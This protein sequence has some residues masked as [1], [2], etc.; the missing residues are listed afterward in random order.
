MIQAIQEMKRVREIAA[1]CVKHGLG[2]K[3]NFGKLQEFIG[4]E[5]KV[6]VT[7]EARNRT[8]PE[9]FRCLL[10][11]LGTTFVKF[12]QILSTRVDLLPREY[13]DELAK[14]QDDVTPVPYEQIR[15]QIEASFGRPVGELFRSFDEKPL[16]S[17]SV[18]QVH[19]AVTNAGEEVVVK[20]QRPGIADKI[21]AD[22]DLLK[23]LA[24]TAEAVFQESAVYSP[25]DLVDAFEASILEEL[26]CR[27]ETR[28]LAEFYERHRS[29][30]GIV[31]PRPHMSLCSP[32][33]VTMDKVAGQKL[34]NSGAM[35][36]EERR[37]MTDIIVEETFN[38]IFVDGLFHAD[39]HPGNLLLVEGTKLGIIDLG[40]VG[41]VS[42]Q[43]QEN[44]LFLMMAIA[45][46]DA[47]SVTRIVCRIAGS[48]NE[49]TDLV[50]FRGDVQSALDRYLA[51]EVS[52]ASIDAGQLIP[53]LMN[54]AVTYRI[55]IPREYALLSRSA[56]ILEGVIQKLSPGM[57]VAETL[58]PY[59]RKA[60]LGRYEG[61]DAGSMGLK[62]LLRMQT[63]A[64]DL[65]MQFSQILMDLE[66]GR[67]QVKLASEELT[68]I[69]TSLK[70]LGVII[71]LGFL[72]CGLTIGIFLSI[73][74]M[75]AS[76]F[77]VPLPA[78]LSFLAIGLL[79]GIVLA[80]SLL[81]GKSFKLNL[82]RLL[83]SQ[84]KSGGE[85]TGPG[86]APSLEAGQVLRT[87]VPGPAPSR[88]SSPPPRQPP[89]P[90]ERS[91][92]SAAKPERE[93]D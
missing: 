60:L 27:L 10:S 87:P 69:N 16:A 35:S 84:P 89:V 44:L 55:R 79:F 90:Q 52:L 22:I 1:L 20:V 80:W 5:D 23:R 88:N 75:D 68:Q 30:P 12:G 3:L 51:K 8:A 78:M 42:S 34:R 82:G 38:E 83:G 40:A 21:R 28:N 91:A 57:N 56:I 73:S 58:M 86:S 85:R 24:R 9:R 15:E 33:V 53:E 61:A 46:R 72:A 39:P 17:A 54:L 76:A 77:G 43:M 32:L 29:R 71:F 47:D 14:L 25:I 2:D 4:W 81:S 65:P 11:E 45:L 49:R 74:K 37:R 6:E 41:R 50:A 70:G 48:S 59:A 31:V 26:D 19:C 64:T 92:D 13:I 66:R 18:A 93:S 63:L 36:P 67:F 7:P 62:T